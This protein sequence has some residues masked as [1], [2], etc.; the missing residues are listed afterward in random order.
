MN[1]YSEVIGPEKTEALAKLDKAVF[2][3]EWHIKN[4]KPTRKFRIKEFKI[5]FEIEGG[6]T[7]LLNQL[8]QLQLTHKTEQHGNN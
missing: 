5:Y 4:G 6:P 3:L 2:Q 1:F 7:K 8:K